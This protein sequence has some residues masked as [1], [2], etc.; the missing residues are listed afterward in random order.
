MALIRRAGGRFIPCAALLLVP[1]VLASVAEGT[2]PIGLGDTLCVLL[3]GLGLGSAEGVPRA[4]QI[5]ILEARLPRAVLFLLV[6][7]ALAVSGV[8]LQSTFQNAMAAP[9]ILGISGGAALG[10]VIAIYSG[11]ADR[12]AFFLPAAAF[13]GALAAMTLVYVLAHLGGRPSPTSL[14]LTGIAVGSLALAGVT[15]IMLWAQE[16]R[17]KEVL[18][19]TM[20]GKEEISWA[21][22]L[23]A[24]GP[25]LL[26]AALLCLHHRFIDALSLGE[27]HALSVGVPVE[28]VRCTLMLLCALASGAAVSVAGTIGFVGLI[29]PHVVRLLIGPRARALLPASFLVGGGF[30]VL[31]DLMA[32]TLSSPLRVLP[33]GIVTSVAGVPFFLWLLYRARRLEA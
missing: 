10:A 11:L 23:L 14:V 26:G 20:G 22:V 18:V 5:I 29:V 4:F 13:A 9:S 15:L 2:V 6:G 31:C 21:E 1:L 28:R 16:Y 33:V 7:G 8:T 24:C 12:S 30:L 32:R 17:M 3:D 25:V 27:E 19:W